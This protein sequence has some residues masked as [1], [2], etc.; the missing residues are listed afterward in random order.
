M[1]GNWLRGITIGMVAVML[2]GMTVLFACPTATAAEQTAATQATAQEEL[3]SIEQQIRAYAK[4]LDQK[5]ADDAA[6]S[7]LASHGISGRG[8]STKTTAHSFFETVLTACICNSFNS[9]EHRFGSTGKEV[10]VA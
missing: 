9:F 2:M 8:T 7:A 1:R 4:S 10:V 5:N 6:A 3:P